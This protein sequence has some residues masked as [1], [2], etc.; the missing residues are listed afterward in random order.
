MSIII[1]MVCKSSVSVINHLHLHVQIFYT[2]TYL[3]QCVY[4]FFTL[5]QGQCKYLS[6][7]FTCVNVLGCVNTKIICKVTLSLGLLSPPNPSFSGIHKVR[8]FY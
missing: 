3:L 2:Y 4:I 8:N 5:T 7:T 6:N 1:Y